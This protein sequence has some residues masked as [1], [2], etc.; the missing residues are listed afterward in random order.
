VTARCDHF[1]T[2]STISPT[3]STT[4]PTTTTTSSTTSTTPPTTT[5]T[6]SATLTTSPITM[7]TSWWLAQLHYDHL[8]DIGS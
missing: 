5:T 8:H 3:A 1:L 6:S 7:T 4:P 2:T